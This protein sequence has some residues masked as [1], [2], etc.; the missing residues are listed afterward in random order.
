MVGYRSAIEHLDD[1]MRA[2]LE[3]MR[4]GTVEALARCEER[5]AATDDLPW[6]RLR[7]EVTGLSARAI[8]L[9]RRAKGD[10]AT[11]PVFEYWYRAPEAN[12]AP[13]GPVSAPLFVWPRDG[14]VRALGPPQ[15]GIRRQCTRPLTSARRQV[16]R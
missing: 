2:V 4:S 10:M 11:L 9:F 13:N 12:T 5:A 7:F 3:L 8:D 14:S 16:H 6:E 1:L 15:R